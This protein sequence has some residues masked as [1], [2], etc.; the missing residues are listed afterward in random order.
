M[1]NL[2]VLAVNAEHL[3][4]FCVFTGSDTGMGILEPGAKE[5]THELELAVFGPPPPNFFP[6]VS[7]GFSKGVPGDARPCIN[8]PSWLSYPANALLYGART[9]TVVVND[10]PEFPVLRPTTTNLKSNAT[11]LSTVLALA[12]VRLVLPNMPRLTL[13]ELAEFRIETKS[14]IQPFRRAMLRLSKDLNQAIL[15]DMTLEDVRREAS[16]LIEST[17]LPELAEMKDE[18]SRPTRPWHRRLADLAT[19]APE[20]A[21]AFA[22]MPTGLAIATALSKTVGLLADIRDAQLEREGLG[23]RGGFHYLLKL[24]AL[25][26]GVLESNP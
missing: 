15:S 16:F 22:T 11:Q 3:R 24:D 2:M 6:T 17:V 23:K 10:A 9:G 7:V 5:L 12:A 14:L 26:T 4:D 18:L 19:A 13:P 1:T 25:S 21:G 8:S 20:I